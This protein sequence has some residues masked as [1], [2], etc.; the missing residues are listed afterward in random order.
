[1]VFGEKILEYKE[2]I[3][4]DIDNLIQI[5]SVS[6]TEQ[7][8]EALRYI[9]K[10]AEEM[11]FKTK[12]VE[13]IAGHAEYGEG[14]EIAGVLAHVDVV[15]AGEG[16]SVEPY[17]LTEKD[18][19]LY[20]RGIVDDKGSAVIALYCLKALKDNGIVPNKR[21]RVIFGAA[22]EIGMNDM[23]TYFS[24]EEMP[25]MAFTPDSEYGICNCEKGIL[26]LEVSSPR[27]DGTT[28]TEFHAGNA[29]NAVPSKAY[30]LADCT[31]AEDTKLRRYADEEVC[32]YDFV[33]GVDG[34]KITASGKAAHGSTPEL[35]LNS[36]THLI[37]VLAVNFGH[38]A[39][40]SL[41][42]FIDDMIGFETD[43]NSLGIAC[44]DKQSGEL[45]VNV[46]RVDI[47]ENVSKAQVDIR[48][49]VSA[50]C[51]E[52]LETIKEKASYE[53]LKVS[54]MNHEQ[55]LC[56]SENAP[57]I[58]IL[59]KAYKTVTEEE[60]EVYSTGGGTYARTLKNNGVAFGPVFK[61]DNSNIH[62]ADESVDKENF[63]RH[64]KICLQAIY[65][66]ATL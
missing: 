21:I 3:L 31:E 36:A 14:K 22:E 18:G 45:T 39:L 30:A 20:G 19:R 60:A 49:P 25:T 63:L 35:G 15:P 29:V 8:G 61:G 11:G 26:Q 54:V 65:G 66:F 59:K 56:V 9:L 24:N 57:I 5:R 51:T 53:G 43:G 48:Y 62:D 6:A 58:E 40:G 4:K 16:W 44:S 7:A 37:R 27:H 12:N 46:G 38:F 28:L 33:Y 10:R 2:E 55:P 13:N 23:Q 47:D 34:L 41:C 50:S 17:R 1:M 42:S 32:G 64:A 52:I